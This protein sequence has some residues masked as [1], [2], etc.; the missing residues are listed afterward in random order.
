MKPKVDDFPSLVRWVA[1]RYHN[2]VVDSIAS[3][4]GISGALADRWVKGKVQSPKIETLEKF[5]RAY[6]LNFNWVR[7]LLRRAAALI[8]ALLAAGV[9]TAEASIPSH[10]T[11]HNSWIQQA[12]IDNLRL[13]GTKIVAL[14]RWATRGFSPIVNL[15]SVAYAAA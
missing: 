13:I 3:R 11:Y 5:C 12:N 15:P 9:C 6:G 4:A 14:L 10:L 1:D 2:G 7:S 8:I